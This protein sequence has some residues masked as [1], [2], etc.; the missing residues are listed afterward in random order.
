VRERHR[1]APCPEWI[2]SLRRVRRATNAGLGW[3]DCSRV[4]L[5]ES[6]RIVSRRPVYA[7]GQ[8]LRVSVWLDA[9]VA[10]FER[11]GV[12]LQE[13][14]Q[15][16]ALA[17]EEDRG[18]PEMVCEAARQLIVAT[19]RLLEI[20]EQLEILMAEVV[21]NVEEGNVDPRP[22]IAA[23]RPPAAHWY[24][25]YCPPLP[26]N[27]IQLLLQRRRRLACTASAD[28]PRRVPPG[29]AP[30]FVS[31][32]PLP[33]TRKSNDERKLFMATHGENAQ[34][35][36]EEIRAMR[37][38]IPNLV[39]PT[40]KGEGRRLSTAATVPPELIE[41]TTVAVKNNVA[42]VR[43]GRPEPEVL[44]DLGDFAEAYAPFAD[45]LEALASFVRHSVT[46]AR[47]TVGNDA[48]DTYALTQRL[49]K[50]PGTADLAPLADAM[51]RAL[52]R[53]GR[54]KKASPAPAPATTPPT[55]PAQ[56]PASPAKQ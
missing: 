19:T 3:I 7:A 51:S 42:L 48:L 39:F 13:T 11:A 45:E 25:R 43:G 55:P 32:C 24:L 22:V 1:T 56:T 49:A 15:S 27:R 29:R 52:G 38:K 21:R 44:R 36:V 40:V 37:Q 8:V 34:A 4:V 54:K 18:A 16:L 12:R 33:S 28:A 30:P 6:F 23:P 20:Q 9:A 26:G 31:I 5:E 14:H 47:S 53:R 41:L 46:T 2:R 10:R 35:L 50:R 17:P